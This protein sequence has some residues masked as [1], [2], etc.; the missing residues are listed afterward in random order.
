MAI[1]NQLNL[2]VHQIDISTQWRSQRRQSS[3]C[4]FEEVNYCLGIQ[5]ERDTDNKNE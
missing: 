5:L 3:R 1:A 2:E 4:W